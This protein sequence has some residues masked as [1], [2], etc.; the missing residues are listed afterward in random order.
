MLQ[1]LRFSGRPLPAAIL[2]LA[3]VFVTVF[4]STASG[5]VVPLN[6][7]TFDAACSA[8]S[9]GDT[10]TVPA[11]SY[12]SQS[13]KCTKAV[14]IQGAGLSTR[15]QYL[16]FSGANGPTVTDVRLGGL[17][18][19]ASRNVAV[20]RATVNNQTYIEGTTGFL[21]DHI[22]WEPESSSTSWGNGD[23][24]DIYPDRNDA[25]SHD[26]TIQ[27]SV[28]HGLRSP[29][30]TAHPD[31]IQTY[32]R[33]QSHTGIKILRTKFYDNECINIRSNPGDE[34]T[35][36]NNQ[37]GDSVQGI[38]GC[39]YYAI[40]VGYANVMA[41]YNTFTGSQSVQQTPTV[42]GIHQTWIG[43]A[44]N[45]FSAGCGSGGASGATMVDN[46]WTGQK[47][48]AQDK[49][50]SSLKLNS[51]GSPQ[52]GSPL[53][54]AGDPTNY[55]ANDFNNN[56]RFSGLAPDAGAIESGSVGSPPP[57]PPVDTTAPQTTITSTPAD[58][59]STSASIAFNSS[60]AGST[61]EC[62]LDTGAY[63]TCTSPK[64]YNNLAVGP[65]T[66]S[67]RAT[68][69]A[70]NTDATPA[71]ATWTISAVPPPADTTAPQTTITSTPADGTSTSASI[72]FNS[73]EAGSTFE[74]KLDTGAYSTC[75]SPKSYNNLAVGP[76][77]ISIRATDTA[78]NTDA[79]PATA[80]WTIAAVPPPPPPAD[81]TAPTVKITSGPSV[82]SPSLSSQ[83][84]FAFV[85]SDNM[86]AADDLTFQCTLDADDAK[87]CT[88]PTT[89]Q[90]L[91]PGSHTFTVTASD[92][93]GNI[94]APASTTWTIAAPTP[95]EEPSTP[96]PP[97]TTPEPPVQEPPVIEEPL[98]PPTV[99]LVR[100]TSGA[101]FRSWLRAVAEA[102]DDSG[103]HHVE[104]WL[105]SKRF[106]YDVSAPYIA[107]LNT[108]KVP[109]G[110]HTLVARAVDDQ[111][112]TASV[113]TSVERV[114]GARTSSTKTMRVAASATDTST[115]LTATGPKRGKLAIGLTTCGDGQAKVVK[116]VT[117]KLGPRGRVGES[118][119]VGRLCVASVALRSS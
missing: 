92:A 17:E 118:V 112:L 56:A 44:G 47:C 10:I 110:A 57:P 97:T 6:G 93:A 61:F 50:V 113:G 58:G 33:G 115:A 36:E 19:K 25:A 24:V 29:S 38:S 76:H 90:D 15:V 37:F 66:I 2:S 51:D 71:T 11:G 46:V 52:S 35:L 23:M 4:A 73:S 12:S 86:T 84:A 98:V 43:N 59:T 119:P 64:S 75:T 68:D 21:L 18:S 8:A 107:T 28:L 65:H 79:T 39:G 89:V 60:E 49:Q 14:T 80:T 111:G 41:R 70:T 9:A 83:A 94:S 7:R 109:V 27:D 87:D 22:I 55:P 31:A 102:T 62:K 95:P 5:A 26:I 77:T 82:V 85:G 63:S 101:Q 116:T 104:F 54:D 34:L 96:T 32:N 69:T 72:A 30:T 20:K 114:S 74:C 108:G 88:S 42:S 48:G 40:D 78:T 1:L 103:V 106:A 53:I 67:I 16:G 91:S 81:T 105:D 100:P 45:G 99:T 13:I 117:L 3:T